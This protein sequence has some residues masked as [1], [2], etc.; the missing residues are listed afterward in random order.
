MAKACGLRIGP[1]RF[2]LFV[3]DGS[4]KKPKV[5]T[6]IAGAIPP[7]PEDPVGAAAHALKAAIKAHKIPKE[8]LM[9][10][11]DARSAA[12]RRVN[13][14]VADPAKIESV[15]KFEVESQLPQFNIDDV[16]VDFHVQETT[17]DS[18]S[19]LVTA[20]PKEEIG[21]AIRLCEAAGVEPLEVEV[22]NTAL[23]NAATG[24]GLC[25]IDSAQ[26]LVHIGEE[27]TAVAVVDGGKV[28]EMRVIQIGALSYSQSGTLPDAEAPSEDESE[29]DEAERREDSWDTPS[30]AGPIERVDEIVQRLRR[31]LSRTISASRTANEL[32]VVYIS[33]F[34]PFGLVGSDILGIPILAFE[35]CDV[36]EMGSDVHSEYKS[37]AVAYGAALGQLGG[38]AIKASLRREELKFTGTMERLE[39][40]L[41][42]LA[43][44]VVTFLGVWNIF[45]RFERDRIDD[46][47]TYML[48]SSANFLLGNPSRGRAG[49]LTDPPD[50]IKTYLERTTGKIPGTDPPEYRIDK[51]LNR[52]DQLGLILSMLKGENQK[53]KRQLGE[54]SDLT[55]PQS[56]FRAMTLVLDVL[57]QGEEKYGRVSLR[58]LTADYREGGN[59]GDHVAVGLTL[60]FFAESDLEATTNYELFYQDLADAEK[61]PW[62]LG[63]KRP[64]SDPIAEDEGS[65]RGIYLKGLTIN[66]NVSATQQDKKGEEVKS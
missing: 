25:L 44:L 15:I 6:S 18:S 47:L 24:A 20:V 17:S 9:V 51:E 10:A 21:N 46:D 23:I 26:V 33:G 30:A 45:I 48:N 66:I 54:G 65:E 56:A 16:V 12:F 40:P 59:L 58:G 13:L 2:E 49:N 39:L 27:S 28:R 43:L 60:S 5:V 35:G 7:D 36:V 61:Y 38:G 50:R 37:G 53:L 55:Q 42:V 41:A 52:F 14:P 29:E 19:V 4:A 62:Y 31:E 3:L 34:E 22:E 32:D 63:L 11:I 64:K 1:R 57:A 8:N